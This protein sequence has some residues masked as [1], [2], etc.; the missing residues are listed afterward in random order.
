M[1]RNFLFFYT[2]FFNCGY[3][4]GKLPLGEINP[5]KNFKNNHLIINNFVICGKPE[6]PFSGNNNTIN[7]EPG[8]Y[9]SQ[10]APTLD[11]P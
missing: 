10:D 3:F 11:I 2:P 5:E 9:S 7:A 8:I 1:P 4:G 6:K